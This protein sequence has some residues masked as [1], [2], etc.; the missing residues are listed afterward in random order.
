MFSS[1][2][3]FSLEVLLD[4]ALE[5]GIGMHWPPCESPPCIY[6][7]IHITDQDQI[8]GVKEFHVAKAL[9]EGHQ[10]HG[11]PM[12]RYGWMVFSFGHHG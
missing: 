7:Y 1:K 4:Q 5:Q 6:I 8:V 3:V 12:S 9:L 11:P 10:E 2:I